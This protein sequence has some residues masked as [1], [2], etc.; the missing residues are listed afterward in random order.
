[1]GTLPNL[2]SVCSFS[3]YT[4]ESGPRAYSSVWAELKE[5]EKVRIAWVPGSSS[6]RGKILSDYATRCLLEKSFAKTLHN[7]SSALVS[8]LKRLK[9]AAFGEQLLPIFSRPTI[10][11]L[12]RVSTSSDFGLQVWFHLKDGKLR[13][14]HF[15]RFSI[16]LWISLNWY[17]CCNMSWRSFLFFQIFI[18]KSNRD[19]R[20]NIA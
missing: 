4:F 12:C 7:I 2:D 17:F 6:S 14:K 19:Y 3:V 1:M 13:M 15:R 16:S 8:T 5:T 11:F 20:G 18:L 9:W 10:C